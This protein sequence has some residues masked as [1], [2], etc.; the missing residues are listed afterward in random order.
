MKRGY[1]SVAMT[2]TP[3]DLRF[4]LHLREQVGIRAPQT[5]G[6]FDPTLQGHNSAWAAN[7]QIVSAVAN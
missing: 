4:S 6:P 3:H 2:Y 1:A 5:R 7:S